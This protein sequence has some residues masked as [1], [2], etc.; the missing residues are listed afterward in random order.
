MDSGLCGYTICKRAGSIINTAYGAYAQPMYKVDNLAFK[1][2][3]ITV[4]S[5]TFALNVCAL[6]VDN[7]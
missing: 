2:Q 5:E 7:V 3:I 4:F 1:S 6:Y